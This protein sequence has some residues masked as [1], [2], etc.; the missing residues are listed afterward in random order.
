MSRE[1]GR[2]EIYVRPYPDVETGRWQISVY[3]GTSPSWSQTGKELFYEDLDGRRMVVS[4]E[5][6]GDFFR[7]GVPEPAMSAGVS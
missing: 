1:S 5:A 2:A 7:T 6:D 3:G 4:V